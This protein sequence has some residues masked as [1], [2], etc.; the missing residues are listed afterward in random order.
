MR[1]LRR[2]FLL[3]VL[4]AAVPAI[5]QGP[6]L[7]RLTATIANGASLSGSVYL[8]DQPIVAIQMPATWTTADLTFQGSNDGTNFFDVYN[9]SGDE[10]LVTAA[11]NRYIV[12]SPFEFQW[13]RYVKIR[14]GTTGTPV[15]QGGARTITL[16]T[17]KVQ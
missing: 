10:Y 11:A 8:V 14:S 9:M 13:A 15:T 17:R 6:F 16:V 1:M 7:S 2:S 12:L 3:L 4:C 5:A